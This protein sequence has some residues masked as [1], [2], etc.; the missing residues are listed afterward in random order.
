MD[1]L[2]ITDL[3]IPTQIGIYAWEKQIK[4]KVILDIEIGI[5]NQQAARYNKIEHSIDYAKLCEAITQYVSDTPFNLIENLAESVA[6]LIQ[7]EFNVTWLKLKARK[8]G[9]V[10]NAKHAGV[11]IERLKD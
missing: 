8:P 2:F 9:A 5:D 4:Q 10:A 3:T 1:T 6:T 11:V 7:D